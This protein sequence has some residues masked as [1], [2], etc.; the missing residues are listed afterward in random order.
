M[1]KLFKRIRLKLGLFTRTELREFAG[2]MI[3]KYYDGGDSDT[4]GGHTD[5]EN[6]IE[7]LKNN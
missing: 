2:N 3:W 1:K 7:D 5:I 4:L 6:F